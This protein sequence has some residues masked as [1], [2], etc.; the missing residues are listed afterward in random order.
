M[1]TCTAITSGDDNTAG[2]WSGGLIPS[3]TF[4]GTRTTSSGPTAIGATS[5]PVSAAAQAVT[6]G[7][8]LQIAGEYYRVA[9][10]VAGGSAGNIIIDAPTPTRWRF[11]VE[12]DRSGY[13]KAINAEGID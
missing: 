7:K 13:I 12:R 1:A 10:G 5:I 8:W 11:E 2:T 3:T 6:A 4:A 9:T